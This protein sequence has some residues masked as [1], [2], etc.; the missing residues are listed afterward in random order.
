M[1]NEVR[2]VCAGGDYT[3]KGDKEYK[4]TSPSK[5]HNAAIIVKHEQ[6]IAKTVEH[7]KLANYLAVYVQKHTASVRSLSDLIY[8]GIGQFY[9]E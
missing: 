9:N 3:V 7:I 8:A 4:Q 5:R 2:G 6:D 1:N